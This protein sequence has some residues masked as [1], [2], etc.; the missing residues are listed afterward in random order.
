MDYNYISQSQRPGPDRV[1]TL[2]VGIGLQSGGLTHW[3][4]RC[5]FKR[6]CSKSY[7]SCGKQQQIFFYDSMNIHNYATL[8]SKGVAGGAASVTESSFTS[9]PT[10][11]SST[12]SNSKPS[13]HAAPSRLFAAGRPRTMV[14]I[15]CW[16]TI[17]LFLCH[18]SLIITGLL[19]EELN[20]YIYHNVCSLSHV[21]K[22]IIFLCEL[23]NTCSLLCAIRIA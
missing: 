1:S 20:N 14:N 16:Y 19:C 11:T 7:L 4:I 12:A 6:W 10:P 22:C 2:T 18:S 9:S 3:A 5:P 13:L 21:N 8:H 23:F 15:C 17:P